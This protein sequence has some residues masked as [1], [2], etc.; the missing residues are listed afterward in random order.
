MITQKLKCKLS[1]NLFLLLIFF[2]FMGCTSTGEMKIQRS[3]DKDVIVTLKLSVFLFRLSAEIDG[4][5]INMSNEFNEKR[6]QI[7]IAN[8]DKEGSLERVATV[9]SPVEEKGKEGWLYLLLEPGSYYMKIAS[10]WQTKLDP[11]LFYIPTGS[12]LVY[13][14]SFSFSCKGG[15]GTE[16]ECLNIQVANETEQAEAIAEKFFKEYLPVAPFLAESFTNSLSK[17]VKDSL[18]PVGFATS[19]TSEFDFPSWRKSIWSRTT[20]I[21]DWISEPEK[22][23]TPLKNYFSAWHLA[24]GGGPGGILV[25][26]YLYLTFVLPYTAITGEA[27]QYMWKS[28]MER[29][30]EEL[31]K[32]DLQKEIISAIQ[33]E[34]YGSINENPTEKYLA[35]QN[36]EVLK[37]LL[38]VDIIH[39]GLRECVNRGEF[40][41]EISFCVKLWNVA[42]KKL[43][44]N[45]IFIYSNFNRRSD[46]I[47]PYFSLINASECREMESY[48]DDETRT[49]FR[50]E[51]SN[52]I[53]A[54]AQVLVKEMGFSENKIP[55]N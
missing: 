20:G 46:P 55:P 24:G 4:K 15:L 51:I 19:I 1:G 2:W 3:I 23:P 38:Q 7:S 35:E 14:G 16:F 25:G 44:Y 11:I 43:V 29:H 41:P 32:F 9:Y 54:M 50:T 13:G 48:C 22:T 36:P 49:V 52:S 39:I 10:I 21:G 33:K 8:I 47:K 40:S 27:S 42:S 30:M 45:K 18:M 26:Y 5:P 12:S 31:S 17:S 37:N 53:N 28:C 34:I 6:M